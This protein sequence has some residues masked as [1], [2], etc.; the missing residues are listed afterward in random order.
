MAEKDNK[1]IPLPRL[2]LISDVS[3]RLYDSFAAQ[4]REA[5]S[6]SLDAGSTK[7]EISCNAGGDPV[8]IL[9]ADDGE[10]LTADDLEKELIAL[11]GSNKKSD[12]DTIGHIGIGFYALTS[13][14]KSIQVITKR[15][16]S[17][18]VNQIKIN[19]EY[20]RDKD[21]ARLEMTEAKIGERH[22]PTEGPTEEFASS[23]TRIRLIEPHADIVETFSDPTK[24]SEFKRE[25]G[26][27]LPVELNESSAVFKKDSL[28]LEKLKRLD[29][30]TIKVALN[31]DSIQRILY[32]DEP[33]QSLEGRLVHV[34][35]KRDGV[36]FLGYI[37]EAPE[38]I[39]PEDWYGFTLRLSNVAIGLPNFFGYEGRGIKSRSMRLTADIHLLGFPKEA[40]LIGRENFERRS[41]HYTN[42][43]KFIHEQIDNFVG[44]V[45]QA[46]RSQKEVSNALGAGE[47]IGKNLNKLGDQLFD[48]VPLNEGKKPAAQKLELASAKKFSDTD[49][50]REMGVKVEYRQPQVGG[51]KKAK[52]F[53]IGYN[54]KGALKPRAIVFTEKIFPDQ[55]KF[56]IGEAEFVLE[57]RKG[58][59]KDA[60]IEIDYSK[61]LILIN[62]R[63]KLVGDEKF[64]LDSKLVGMLILIKY[65][66]DNTK[67]KK[68][69]YDVL[70]KLISQMT[71]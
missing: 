44:D 24:F 52:K 36:R 47:K 35:E 41:R 1:L 69:Y 42:L 17:K 48:L 3:S 26:K 65:A 2:G 45:N 49:L 46:Y 12:K 29:L 64:Y 22:N 16:N 61:Q 33:K 54:K 43:K 50:V 31:G 8:S 23:Y 9:I 39:S 15:K 4:I 67:D 21:K 28:L 25:L 60:V 38:K 56:K 37:Y 7:C 71:A 19:C 63:S 40:V 34:D 6:N 59:A 57:Y 58:K 70:L 66:F 5:V 10:G 53:K 32:G 30:K 62:I 13:S 18:V 51:G 11:G 68:E 20:I 27:I 55:F 14:C